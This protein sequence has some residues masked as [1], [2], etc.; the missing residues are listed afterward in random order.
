MKNSSNILDSISNEF[1]NV[2]KVRSQLFNVMDVNVPAP[3]S[4]EGSIQFED[5]KTKIIYTDKG[6]YLG[7]TGTQYESIQPS[8]FLDSIV[9]S[10][11]GCNVDLN[12]DKLEYKQFKGGSIIDFKIPSGIIGFKNTLN[13]SEDVE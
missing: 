6:A 13:K 3:F 7:T 10:V 8:A 12:L 9:Q 5:P 11:D 1:N 4:K 2:E